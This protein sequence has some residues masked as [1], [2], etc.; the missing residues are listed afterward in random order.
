MFAY[1][2]VSKKRVSFWNY[3]KYAIKRQGLY[4]DNILK[5]EVYTQ[6]KKDRTK[7]KQVDARFAYESCASLVD[8]EQDARTAKITAKIHSNSVIILCSP[9]RYAV[10]CLGLLLT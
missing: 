2:F 5:F 6:Q 1:V 9:N 10:Q 8:D 4:A 3:A 7:A